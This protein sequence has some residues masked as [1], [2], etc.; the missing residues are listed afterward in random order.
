MTLL[1]LGGTTEG[2]LLSANLHHRG[3]P[4]IYSQAGIARTPQLKCEILS[5]GFSRLGGLGAFIQKR[6][7]SAILD[8]THPY[9][10]TIT[11]KAAQAAKD[12]AIPCLRFQRPG[13]VPETKDDWHTFESWDALLAALGD[14][15]SLFFTTGQLDQ[16][17][18]H[19]LEIYQR[20]GQHQVVRTV[21]P[22]R[23]PLPPATRWIQ[24]IGP[25]HMEDERKIM[26]DHQIDTLISK[27]SGGA[28]TASKF[29][30]ARE[31]GV[32]V[33]MLRR[34]TLPDLDWVLSSVD[35]C[36]RLVMQ[37][38]EASRI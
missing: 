16:P 21:A 19:Q 35:D 6:A 23:T 3:V 14:R 11:A 25:F 27:N 37:W 1:V 9:A 7:I 26:V 18:L 13:W 33:F 20:R 32:A 29:V 2:H 38:F 22:P 10:E 4:L 34:P 36:E 5:G 12:C 28:A 31:L 17:T 15:R 30:A 8:A 24:A